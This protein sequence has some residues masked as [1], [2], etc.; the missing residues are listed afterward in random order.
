MFDLL[1]PDGVAF[2]VCLFGGPL[3]ILEGF[4]YLFHLACLLELDDCLFFLFLFY[5]SFSDDFRATR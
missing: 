5:Q 2:G 1:G 4:I 3:T